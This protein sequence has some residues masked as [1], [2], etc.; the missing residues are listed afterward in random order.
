MTFRGR[1]RP[2]LFYDSK[3]RWNPAGLVLRILRAISASCSDKG[4]SGPSHVPWTCIV[5]L[6]FSMH[7]GKAGTKVAWTVHLLSE[8]WRGEML[9]SCSFDDENK[10]TRVNLSVPY[11]RLLQWMRTEGTRRERRYVQEQYLSCPFRAPPGWCHYHQGLWHTGG[12][13]LSRLG[14]CCS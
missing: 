6:K 4:S 14:G 11:K 13:Q 8:G 3:G 9:P 1:F 5:G 12:R 10:G 2:K 7:A